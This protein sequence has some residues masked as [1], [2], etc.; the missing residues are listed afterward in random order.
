MKLKERT[1]LSFPE[2]ASII[3]G[4]GIG[5]GILSVPYLASRNSIRD[6]IIILLICTLFNIVLHLLIAELSLNNKGAQ[7]VKCFN[8]ELFSGLFKKIFTWLAFA[9]MGFSV[10]VNVG[11]YLTGAAAVFESWFGVS[12]IA[13]MLVFYV[14]CAAV[15]FFGVKLVGICEK[16]AVGGMVIV[17]L[18][19]LFAVLRGNV[20]PMPTRF[21]T[22][23]N[24]LA[25]FGMVSFSLSA[26]M[27]T[28][29]VVKGLAMKPGRIRAA[30]SFGI[31]LNACVIFLVTL[32]TLMGTGQD[33]TED[34]AL[35]DLARKMGGWVS[36]VGYIFT[37]L[38]LAT[39]FWT[40]T[41][42]LRDIIFEQLHWNRDICWL[43][44]SLPPLLLA[45]AA[46]SS[47]VTLSRIASIIMV[48]TSLGI[49]LAYNRS[50][51]RVGRSE[52][53]GSF[54]TLPFQIIVLA[55]SLL[56][57]I[58]SVLKVT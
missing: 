18:L 16:Y 42:N 28:P 5:A 53:L 39:S 37:L 40:N 10:I 22:W 50:R 32:T 11:A 47:F 12:R 38:A 48:V 29:Q 9:L 51:K 45:I 36:I 46:A 55:L 4:H 27:S 26:V 41:L 1:D 58:G 19:L 13:G 17:V 52:L 15:V 34:G 23:S 14:L 3:V 54:G 7:F 35:V 6:I 25:L 44:A 21:R 8:A 49:I 24:V 30:I 31:I 20:Y 56:A 43:A 57:T 33:I 2:A